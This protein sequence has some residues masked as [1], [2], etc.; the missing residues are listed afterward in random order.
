MSARKGSP[1]Q[2]LR[3]VSTSL[4]VA[5]LRSTVGFA[6]C[7][8]IV[9]RNETAERRGAPTA[10]WQGRALFA[11]H[12]AGDWQTRVTSLNEGPSRGPLQPA[13]LVR[14]VMCVARSPSPYSGSA[15]TK[16]IASCLSVMS[17]N[18]RPLVRRGKRELPLIRRRGERI[19]NYGH[20]HQKAPDPV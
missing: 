9:R 7:D 11:S 19:G 12:H 20:T 17:R 5:C 13:D 16:S 15:E 3:S 8:V 14:T 1:L 4:M 2:L 6:T 10:I 18:Q